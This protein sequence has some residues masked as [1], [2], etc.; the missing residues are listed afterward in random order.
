MSE[1]NVLL[2]VCVL[3]FAALAKDIAVPAAVL[4]ALA[5]LRWLVSRVPAP[6]AMKG[7]T[8]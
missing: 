1:R 3:F 7:I 8:P 6:P 5:C 4:T 2:S